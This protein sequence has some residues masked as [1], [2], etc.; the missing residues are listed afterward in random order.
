MRII[1]AL[2][3]R[4]RAAYL[5]HLDMQRTLQRA[6]RRADMPLLYSQGFNPHPLMA[7]AGAL[8]TGFESE[9]EWFD[10]RLEGDIGPQDF[11]ARL[12]AVLPEGM[13]VSHAM[14]APEDL[15]TLTG[16][17]A[18]AR[19]TLWVR[20]ER[21]CTA[22]EVGSALDTLLHSE[23]LM[24]QKRTKS[25]AMVPQNIRPQLYEAR[26]TGEDGG[27]FTL[28]V[29]GER[30][31]K[32]LSTC[33]SIFWG[34]RALSD[35]GGR[36][37]TSTKCRDYPALGK[38][39][40]NKEILVDANKFA[41]RV[42]VVEDGTPVE[43]Y[44][45]QNGTE[46]LVGNIYLGKVQNVLPGMQA[47]FVDIGLE[48]NAFLYA[49][50]VFFPG[51]QYDELEQLPE[52][53]KIGDLLKP[54]QNVLVQVAKDPVGT[55]GARVTTH[56]TLAG[57]SLVLM[58]TVDY[59]GVSRRIEKE[60]ERGRLRKI[61]NE[62]KPK[63][64]GVIVRTAS[65]GKTKEAFQEDL[66][67]LLTLY[68]DIEKK[69]KK[70][71]APA[72]MHA[73]QSLLFRTVRDLLM[74]DV[75]RVFV[76]DQAAFE[77]L[78]EIADV[79][80]PKLKPRILYKDS[81]ALFERYDTEAKIENALSRQVWL[82][83]GGYL[84]ID[85]AEALTVIDVNT[86]KYVGKDN[87]E[88]TITNTNCEAAREIAV[89]LRL[90]DIG[91]I[92]IID[93]IDMDKEADRQKV[94]QTL[95]DAMRDDHTRSHV[96]G[97]THLGLVELTRKKTGRSIGDTLKVTCPYCQGEAKVSPDVAAAME[98]L[99]KKDGE[100]FPEAKDAD[101]YVKANPDMHMEKFTVKPLPDKRVAEA[102]KSCRIM[103]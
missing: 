29:L 47:A 49:G 90:R 76:N 79:M 48:K 91:G 103:H 14:E 92:V 1:A 102:K 42:A 87:L 34:Q 58:P 77:K 46:R 24:V 8:S 30:A 68:E 20:P 18:A 101:F 15:S 5:S 99:M 28:D 100:L 61:L 2:H 59:V 69:S 17:L 38:E 88:K 62:I 50:D 74:K 39:N 21:A 43:L 60:E 11:E 55:K 25:G 85:R 4:G 41:I 16:R 57:R 71:K 94:L 70:T 54:G 53:R 35:A 63:N 9:R 7:F 96:F 23:E 67:S 78:K 32:R 33:C 3:E 40:M 64:K 13:S 81:E 86:G 19:Y 51:D 95:K 75:D 27:S 89:Q 93:F 45:E 44:V 22:A 26:L 72:L 6:L 84:V 12:N 66:E 36:R 82:K 56:I 31:R 80:A 73:E 37:C 83:S 97:F 52:T 65:A 98:E 10:V